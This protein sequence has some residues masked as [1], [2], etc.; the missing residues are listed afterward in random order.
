[1]SEPNKALDWADRQT[2]YTARKQLEVAAKTRTCYDED[3]G[4]GGPHE[5]DTEDRPK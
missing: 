5:E 2:A 1:M 3:Q 4:Q